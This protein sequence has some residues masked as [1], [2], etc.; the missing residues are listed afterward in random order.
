MN[1]TD[2]FEA[3]YSDLNERYF[4]MLEIC[5]YLDNLEHPRIIES[6]TT[7]T[8]PNIG[9]G[10]DGCATIVFQEYL[11]SR[12][13]YDELK[14]MDIPPLITIDIDIHACR[15][16][17]ML[18]EDWVQIIWGDS[19]DILGGL[20]GEVDLLYL[21]SMDLFIEGTISIDEM[22]AEH[23]LKELLVAQHLLKKNTL[24][25]VDD[26]SEEWDYGKGKLIKDFFDAR[27]IQPLFSGTQI[28]WLWN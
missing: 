14:D 26:S 10:T 11:K 23:H 9:L 18:T 15:L 8:S 25:V 27:G 3:N 17:N 6:G 21:D 5:K 4:T 12:F 13:S 22:S 2:N 16:A 28:G 7:R 24:I 19:L 20:T 1:F